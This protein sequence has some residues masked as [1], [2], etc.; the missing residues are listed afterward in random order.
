MD[1][2]L[3]SV[4]HVDFSVDFH[5]FLKICQLFPWQAGAVS[6]LKG[7]CLW[8]AFALCPFLLSCYD[9]SQ[10][11]SLPW[12]A[13]KWPHEDTSPGFLPGIGDL[14]L[15]CLWHWEVRTFQLH[16]DTPLEVSQRQER[17]WHSPAHSPNLRSHGPFFPRICQFPWIHPPQWPK[18]FPNGKNLE[19]GT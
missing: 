18:C 7:P 19:V 1:R 13:P 17:I 5:L 15:Y 11:F 8:S 4:R 16:Y 6:G 9:P 10:S 2:Q 14:C 12:A 3:C